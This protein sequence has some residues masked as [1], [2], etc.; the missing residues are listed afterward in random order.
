MKATL[1]TYNT[2]GL[3][4]S[5]SSKLSKGLV[6]YTDKSNNGKYTYKRA[7]LIASMKSIIISRS[8]FIIPRNKTKEIVLYIK[9]KRGKASSW[10]IDIPQ[11]Y[12]KN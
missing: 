5:E 1:I 2:K 8:T 9:A 11:K 3:N 6:G 7:G 10:L 4:K 12:F